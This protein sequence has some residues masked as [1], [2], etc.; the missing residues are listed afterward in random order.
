LPAPPQVKQGHFSIYM[1]RLDSILISTLA[2]RC[3]MCNR[4]FEP[5]DTVVVMDIQNLIHRFHVDCYNQ[6]AVGMSLFHREFDNMKV[7]S[8]EI[9]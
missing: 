6:L 9:Q 8:T 4:L 1:E 5:N 3:Y 2:P 7:F